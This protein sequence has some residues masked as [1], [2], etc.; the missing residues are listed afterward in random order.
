MPAV[1]N[2]PA[3]CVMTVFGSGPTQINM[4]LLHWS[5]NTCTKTTKSCFL[6]CYCFPIKTL[7]AWKPPVFMTALKNRCSPS[8]KQLLSP[9]YEMM[10]TC[11]VVTGASYSVSLNPVYPAGSLFSLV[12]SYKR[13]RKILLRYNLRDQNVVKRY[14]ISSLSVI[15]MQRNKSC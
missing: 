1:P 2:L 5:W 11:A 4:P 15:K 7:T 10:A 8:G 9:Q 3:V 13:Y 14:R 6:W 12:I